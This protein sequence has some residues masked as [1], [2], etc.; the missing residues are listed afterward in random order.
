MAC[1]WYG[2]RLRLNAGTNIFQNTEA[3]TPLYQIPCYQDSI[4]ISKWL[5]NINASRETSA[6][7]IWGLWC[8]RHVSKACVSNCTPHWILWD[9]VTN[10]CLRY[11]LLVWKSSYVYKLLGNFSSHNPQ[12]GI[13]HKVCCHDIYP[14]TYWGRVTHICVSKLTIIVSDNGLSPGQRQAIIWNND[15]V[16]LIGPLGK[17]VS[18]ILIEI[19][20]FSF[21]KFDLKMSSGKWW[22]FCFGLNVLTHSGHMWPSISWNVT[23][24]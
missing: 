9:A 17:N 19:Y 23:F 4:F 15:G 6:S 21:K 3:L 22:P 1:M 11:L 24:V 13:S 8:Q 18:E 12:T 2:S 5:A 16:L 20:T 7:Y 14:L 10:P